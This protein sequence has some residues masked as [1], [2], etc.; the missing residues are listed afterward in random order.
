MNKAAFRIIISLI[1]IG[2]LN[3]G[4]TSSVPGRERLYSTVS[5]L[6]PDSSFRVELMDHELLDQHGSNVRFASDVIGDNIVVLNFVYTACNT[7]CPIV[8]AIFS[9]LHEQLGKKLETGVRMVSLSID[10]MTDTPEKLKEY[11]GHFHASPNWIWLTGKKQHV[12]S[13]LK[14]LKVYTPDY[15][16]HAPTIVVGDPVR[17]TWIRF[18]GLTS[19]AT[20]TAKID[21]LLSARK[22]AAQQAGQ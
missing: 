13:I 19:P 16:N 9:R 1:V 2:L 14:G 18:I 10:P 11:A 21:E 5:K 3:F 8:S 22:L 12:D 4:L 15:T 6:L 7:A 20:I 17:N